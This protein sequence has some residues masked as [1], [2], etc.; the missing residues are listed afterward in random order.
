MSYQAASAISLNESLRRKLGA[1]RLMAQKITHD[2]NNYYG[3]L[4]GYISLMEMKSPLEGKQGEYLEAMTEALQA[5]IRLNRV[6]ASIYRQTS[7]MVALAD[8]AALAREVS[9]LHA[10]EHGTSVEVIVADEVAPFLFE[11]SSLQKAIAY[12]CLLAQTTST[13]QPQLIIARTELHAESIS[14]LVLHSRPGPYVTLEMSV[15]LSTYEQDEETA[16]LNPFA[17]SF[18]G[19]NGLGLAELF[20]ILENHDGSLDVS[21]ADERLTLRLHFPYRL[22]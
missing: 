14:E 18:N 12:L 4:Q 11:E 21:K 16:F 13:P 19:D 10:D 8:L 5:G 22:S 6:L 9:R 20:S 2:T 3:I 1:S 15:A 7:A 17:L